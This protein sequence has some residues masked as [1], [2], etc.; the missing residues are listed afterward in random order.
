MA[1][2]ARI[3]G[4]KPSQVKRETTF[5]DLLAAAEGLPPGATPD[6]KMSIMVC[7]WVPSFSA[8]WGLHV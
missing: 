8:H 3:V 6:E 5:M 7:G 1:E 2:A 4:I